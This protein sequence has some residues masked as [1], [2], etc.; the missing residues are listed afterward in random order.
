MIVDHVQL[1]IPSDAEATARAF[2][3]D[4]VGME[5]EAKP[6]SLRSRG[7]FW[8]RKGG[9]SVHLGVE[10]GFRPQRRAHPAFAVED[11]DALA[12]RLEAAGHGVR[13][14]DAVPGLRRFYTH[15]PFENR[16]EFVALDRGAGES[17]ADHVAAHG[18]GAFLRQ[19]ALRTPRVG[20]GCIVTDGR[21]L[22]LVKSR[23]TGRWSTPG[24][25]LEMG[26]T[27]AACA[28]RE[29]REETG[30]SVTGTE[31]VAITNDVV[32]EPAGHYV[33]IWLRAE[34]E[35]ERI[36]VRDSDEI[37]EAAWFSVDALPSPRQPYF[38][39]LLGGRCLPAS[40]P[41]LPFGGG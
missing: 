36:E 29:V 34:A 20:V 39:N 6:V 32:E 40:P 33:T 10:Q 26:E 35:D 5:E 2:W 14:D 21:K 28:V 31:F 16:I 27:P 25:N 12:E 38:E 8:F 30:V 19:P 13:W 37:A 41:N 1:A 9:C 18:H 17:V 23:R 7:G 15:D 22:L 24:G 11:L 4:V 3:G